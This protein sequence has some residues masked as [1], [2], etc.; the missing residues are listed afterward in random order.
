M[1]TTLKI[2]GNICLFIALIYVFKVVF[3]LVKLDSEQRSDRQIEKRAEIM[4]TDSL[5]SAYIFKT[6]ALRIYMPLAIENNLKKN[7]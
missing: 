1:K 3:M 7:R 2:I 4:Y 5:E 6:K